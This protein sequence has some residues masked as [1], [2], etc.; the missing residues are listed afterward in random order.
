MILSHFFCP[1]PSQS[2]MFLNFSECIF[3]MHLGFGHSASSGIVLSLSASPSVLPVFSWYTLS[4]ST[5]SLLD[6]QLQAVTILKREHIGY[7]HS[8][9]ILNPG[10]QNVEH[11]L[12]L[13]YVDKEQ[14][15][16][17]MEENF[18]GNVTETLSWGFPFPNGF[19]Y[20]TTVILPPN[21]VLC[22]KAEG[23]IFQGRIHSFSFLC[24]YVVLSI[25]ISLREQPGV[26][27]KCIFLQW[28]KKPVFQQ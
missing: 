15:P 17:T 5:Y 23:E 21:I 25:D 11:Y 2:C 18:S 9:H 8:V 10:R 13:L 3:H 6:P 27:M 16:G 19:K 14:W 4:N 7:I 28:C 1:I 26:K 24:M 12:F 20:C 22:T